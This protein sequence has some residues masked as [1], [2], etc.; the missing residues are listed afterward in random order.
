MTPNNNNDN[1]SLSKKGKRKKEREKI[2]NNIILNKNKV[3]YLSII[4]L[5]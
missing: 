4:L 1:R 2:S 5:F 3:D